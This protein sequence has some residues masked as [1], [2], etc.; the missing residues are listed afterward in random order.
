MLFEF[1]LSEGRE[2]S[3]V[4]EIVGQVRRFPEISEPTALALN[5]VRGESGSCEIGRATDSERVWRVMIGIE[6]EIERFVDGADYAAHVS[7]EILGI[8][9]M[10]VVFEEE[11]LGWV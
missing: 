3:D 2:K 10:A 7:R 9:D 5:G 11:R 4:A 1:H 8:K 6:L